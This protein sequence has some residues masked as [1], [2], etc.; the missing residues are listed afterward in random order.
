M[1]LH[2][3]I[4]DGI[5]LGRR[6]YLYVANLAFLTRDTRHEAGYIGLASVFSSISGFHAVY[7]TFCCVEYVLGARNAIARLCWRDVARQTVI[8]VVFQMLQK[9]GGRLEDY[10]ACT[11]HRATSGVLRAFVFVQLQSRGE[12]LAAVEA[13]Q[14]DARLRVALELV[15]SE[16]LHADVGAA[17]VA[18]QRVRGRHLVVVAG[19]RRLRVH[20]FSLRLLLDVPQFTQHE[21]VRPGDVVENRRAVIQYVHALVVSQGKRLRA[22]A[23]FEAKHVGTLALAQ[24]L[25]ALQLDPVHVPLAAVLARQTG[26]TSAA[27]TRR[28]RQP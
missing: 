14:H 9:I 26:Q 27:R 19:C 10:A 17:V 3:N 23:A 5:T 2:G 7:S 1:K 16:V 25:V 21:A 18:E 8:R 15:L 4:S 11:R 12:M 13:R 6:V 22:A 28:Y 24:A 20:P